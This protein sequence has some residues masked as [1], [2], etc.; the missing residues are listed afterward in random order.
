MKKILWIIFVL[1]L[2]SSV[3]AIDTDLFSIDHLDYNWADFSNPTFD[4]SLASDGDDPA[5]FGWNASG[6][7]RYTLSLIHI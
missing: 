2:L 4:G 7:A 5:S 3:S 1:I 6:T